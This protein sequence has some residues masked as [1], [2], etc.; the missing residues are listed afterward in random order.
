MNGEE[1][2]N[3][4]TLESNNSKKYKEYI[5]SYNIIITILIALFIYVLVLAL[6][7]K[8]ITLSFFKEDNHGL[9]SYMKNI[10]T[11][12][13]NLYSAVDK[14]TFNV[15]KAL[16]IIPITVSGLSEIKEEL[17]SPSKRQALQE[18]ELGTYIDSLEKGINN[19][20][21]FLNQLALCFE[22][23]DA[24]DISASFTQLTEYKNT[25]LENYSEVTAKNKK[26]GDL[27]KGEEFFSLSLTYLNE[28]IKLNRET[29]ILVSQRND[30]LLSIDS[31]VSDF[32]KLNTD[33]KEPLQRV[34]EDNGSFQG[35]LS[36]ID[37]D[38]EAFVALYHDLNNVAI[39][40][41]S[42]DVFKALEN[43]FY[44]YSN[45][46]QNLRKA[47]YEESKV[48]GKYKEQDI[49]ELYEGSQEDF[50]NL[51]SSL[52]TFELTYAAYKDK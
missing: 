50:K 26:I 13:N 27:Q 44:K 47:V 21:N 24:Q 31:I 38:S 23:P 11:L 37:R 45:Y 51:Q 4:S 3:K 29:N 28:I 48:K 41:D 32:K 6:N 34:R 30:F 33:Y 20:I 35:I 42:I 1:N 10:H 36:G 39:P 49:Q 5:K 43:C 7:N 25:F 15:E 16:E 12:N 2:P 19:N 46:I 22:N 8:S 40:K 18:E 52:N 17:N 14:E 9:D